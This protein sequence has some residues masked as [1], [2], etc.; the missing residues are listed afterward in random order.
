MSLDERKRLILQAIVEDYINTAEPVGSRS[1]SKRPELNL[2][3]AT[4]RNEMGDLEDMGLL[5]QPHTSAGRIPSKTG[6]RF[7]VDSLMKRYEMTAREIE[8]MKGAMLHKM[9]ELD[10]IVR[11]VSAA[12]S[13]ITNLPTVGL[14]PRFEKGIVKSIKLVK[15]DDASLMVIISTGE[16]MIKNKLLH[17]KKEISDSELE[18]LGRILN[19]NLSGLRLSEIGLKNVMEVQNAVGENTELL[20]EVL[21][22]VHEAVS[23]VD[24]AEVFME[25]ATSILRF[26]EYSDVDRIKEIFDLFEDKAQL[27]E[28][29]K[30]SAAD[31]D[32]KIIIGDEN[33]L[34]ELKNNSLIISP[35]KIS[36]GMT[37]FIGVIGPMRMNYSKIVSSLEFFSKNL[38]KSFK[39]RNKGNN[40]LNEGDE[41]N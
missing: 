30:L 14:L 8:L 27:G 12:F 31:S 26:P 33:P 35:Y 4:I 7:Y 38:E 9:Q 15:I 17:L 24:K 34:P 37:G 41:H 20:T 22:L 18:K 23:Q 6:Y 28:I 13:A 19:E 11:D 16:G 40:A 21:S 2:S 32:V 36:D 3:A 29:I 39:E 5:I 10:K 1:I 25:G